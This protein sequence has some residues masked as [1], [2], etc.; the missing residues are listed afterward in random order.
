MWII[1]QWFIEHYIEV[2]ATVFGIAGVWLTARQNVWCWPVG[3]ANVIFSLIVFFYSR[4][5]ADVL[6]QI[7]YLVM[8]LYGWYQWLWGGE[9][10]TA[11]RIRRMKGIELLVLLLIG[12]VA[13]F[14]MGWL[15][16]RY[17][18]AALPYADSLVAVWG[19][20]GTWAMARKILEHWII[21]IIVDALCT[22]I[23][24]Y[25]ELYLFAILYFIFVILAV[26]GLRLWMRDYRKES[27]S[28]SL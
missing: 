2:A 25:K 28:V 24:A 6:L 15:F 4:L 23:Y 7:F 17:T 13:T 8:T 14:V 10:K 22:G 26:I 5:Y 19:I 3:L 1:L 27:V 16:S 20:L 9:K 18:N 12:A 11:L 21:W